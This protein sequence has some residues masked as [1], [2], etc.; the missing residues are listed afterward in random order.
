MEHQPVGRMV[1]PKRCRRQESSKGNRWDRNAVQSGD[2]KGD[3][4]VRDKILL[5]QLQSLPLQA[6]ITMAE[7][8]IREWYEHFDGNVCISFSGGKDST[9]L[10]DLVHG[11]YPDVPLVFANTGLEYPE[12]QK[13]AREMGAEFVRPKMSFSEVISTYGYPIISKE[14]AEAIHFARRIVPQSLENQRGGGYSSNQGSNGSR[15]SVKEQILHYERSRTELHGQR[16]DTERIAA[17]QNRM[18]TGEP[19]RTDS[20]PGKFMGGYS[21]RELRR[22]N[23]FR[24]QLLGKEPVQQTEMAP[25]EPGNTVHDQPPVLQRDEEKSDG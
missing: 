21:E 7:Q 9:V 11:M 3:D 5:R 19:Q 4:D 23:R 22:I 6:K 18:A 2:R 12:I 1:D 10:T 25:A 16:D 14:V 13:F 8:R 20:G 24:H 15:C 17:R